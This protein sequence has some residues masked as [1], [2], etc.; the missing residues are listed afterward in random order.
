MSM[1]YHIRRWTMGVSVL[2]NLVLLCWHHH[3]LIRE[4]YFPIAN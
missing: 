1:R 4:G 2:D 3:R